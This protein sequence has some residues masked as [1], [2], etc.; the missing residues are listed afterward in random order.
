ML[1]RLQWERCKNIGIEQ[2]TSIVMMATMMVWRFNWWR[3]CM[4]LC[5]RYKTLVLVAGGVGITPFIAVLRD[6]LCRHRQEN[7]SNQHLPSKV[8]LIWCVRNASELQTL[9]SL[10]PSLLFPDYATGKLNIDV[11][12]YI[13]QPKLTSSKTVDR[14]TSTEIFPTSKTMSTRG[15]VSDVRN[16]NLWFAAII[17]AAATG[18]MLFHGIFHLYVVRPNHHTIAPFFYE[19]GTPHAV[20]GP[21]G[22]PFPTWA[23]V[24]LLFISMFLGIVVCGGAVMFA[25]MRLRGRTAGGSS[26]AIESGTNLAD[27][28]GNNASLLHQALITEGSRPNLAG[29]QFSIISTLSHPSS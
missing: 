21:Q 5:Y 28:E 12:A 6:L 26:E 18:T 17:A 11:K 10:S 14:I 27:I 16:S 3:C 7:D 25:W 29:N 2:Y 19:H 20:L 1:W 15:E 4:I 13:T 24:S 22:K 8:H 23:T 9:E